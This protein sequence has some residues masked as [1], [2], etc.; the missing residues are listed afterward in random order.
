VS[1]PFYPLV[2]G[3]L[4]TAQDGADLADWASCSATRKVISAAVERGDS[5]ILHGRKESGVN[6]LQAEVADQPERPPTRQ[7]EA[8]SRLQLHRVDKIIYR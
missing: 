3:L 2:Q 6:R 4:V 8:V 7:Q 5:S 1:I